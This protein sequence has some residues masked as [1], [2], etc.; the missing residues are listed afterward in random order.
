MSMR[1]SRSAYY[2]STFVQKINVFGPDTCGIC[3]MT[4][5]H[6]GTR[7]QHLSVSIYLHINDYVV[8]TWYGTCPQLLLSVNLYTR[9]MI[10]QR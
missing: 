10:V 4:A 3:N 8:C 9:N 6:E 1:G 5:T 2:S 7:A